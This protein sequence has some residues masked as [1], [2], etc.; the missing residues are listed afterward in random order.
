MMQIS[1]TSGVVLVKPVTTLLMLAD[2]ST[3]SATN[4]GLLTLSIAPGQLITAGTNVTLTAARPI[5]PRSSAASVR[6]CAVASGGGSIDDSHHAILIKNST[7][8]VST[9][10]LKVGAYKIVVEEL[11]DTDGERLVRRQVIPFVISSFAGDVPPDV[12]VVHAVHLRVGEFQVVRCAPGQHEGQDQ[13][14]EVLKVVERATGR[15]RIL[16]FNEHGEQI[17]VE[18]VLHGVQQRRLE[19]YGLIHETLWHHMEQLQSDDEVSVI[20]WPP[21][22]SDDAGFDKSADRPAYGPSKAEIGAA[23][24]WRRA[25]AA[26]A[27]TVQELG[28]P[29]EPV[30]AEEVPLLYATL[31]V[32]Q[33][34]ALAQADTV[35]VIFLDNP[36]AA[37]DD[38]GNSIAVARA[39]AAHADGYVGAGVTVAVWEAAPN[40]ETDLDIS[41]RFTLSPT[42]RT[43]H[44]TNVT[45]IIKNTAEPRGHAPECRLVSANAYSTAA[46]RW[47]VFTERATVV[48]QSFHRIPDEAVSGTLSADDVLKDWMVLHYP[49]PTI[50]SAAG[51]TNSPAGEVT[52]PTAEFVNHKGFNTLSVGNHNDDATAMVSTS[53]FRNPISP[54][55][56]RELPELA[57]NGLGVTAAGLTFSGTSQASPAVAGAAALL[58]DVNPLLK[59]WPEGCRAILLASAER[60]IRDSTWGADVATGTDAWDGAGA[61]KTSGAVNI[62][63]QRSGPKSQA[64]RRGWDVGTLYADAFQFSPKLQ[65]FGEEFFYRIQLRGFPPL[66]PTVKIALAWNSSIRYFIDQFVLDAPSP[67]WTFPVDSRIKVDLDLEVVWPDGTPI[68]YSNGFDNSYVVVEFEQPEVLKDDEIHVFIRAMPRPKAWRSYFG[69]AWTYA[70]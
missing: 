56:D 55:G 47:A 37:E 53:I 9:D 39:D 29:S 35:G 49:Y 5:D 13:Y 41:A 15:R 28:V 19:H 48:N 67:I 10:H 22:S 23:L 70:G 57:A 11:L 27:A 36:E 64:R 46:L 42:D 44:A 50:V 45:A 66:S 30:L 25:Q 31:T 4:A 51:N 34:R 69:I 33:I 59:S 12:R 20:I 54:R 68:A 7:I 6:I 43:D 60:N 40:D 26:L 63:E 52:P 32:A 58:Q 21:V 18:R 8:E 2:M 16:G 65:G 17:D 24:V 14:I 38:L 1:G 61:L 62:A 3:P